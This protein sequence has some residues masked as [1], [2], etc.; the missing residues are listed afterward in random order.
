M[1][2]RLDSRTKLLATIAFTVFVIALPPTS[3]SMVVC[4]AV[5]PMAILVSGRVPLNFVARHILIVSPFV[6]VLATWTALYDRTAIHV[7]FGPFTFMTTA[8][9]IRC[10]GIIARFVVTM[11]AL[12][13]LV[14]TTRFTDLLA[15]MKRLGMPAILVMQLG[16]LH[17]YIFLLVDSTRTC[18][19]PAPAENCEASASG[20][21]S[22]RRPQ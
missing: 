3:V 12:I 8:G 15:G 18:C 17:R 10:T 19:G 9:L 2:H 5:W 4:A 14:A 21:N 20:E 16:F 13:G 7:T 22:R 6:A 11:A 1:V